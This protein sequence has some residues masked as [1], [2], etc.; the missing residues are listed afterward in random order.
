MNSHVIHESTV[1]AL[2]GKMAFP[3]VVKRLIEIEVER[4]YAD[5]V[6][7]EKVF[8]D[9]QGD[10]YVERLPIG[11]TPEIATDFKK[12][13][14]VAAIQT[15]QKEEISYPEFLRRIMKA[16]CSSYVVY[17]DGKQ[18]VYYGRKGESYVEKFPQQAVK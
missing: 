10:T 6:R 7:M 16:G 3:V 9:H 18:A 12:A 17:I 5:L 8:Y 15:I 1:Q 14:V 13:D 4:Y 11:P 2:E